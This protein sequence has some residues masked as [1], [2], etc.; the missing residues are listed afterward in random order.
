MTVGIP[1]LIWGVLLYSVGIGPD[2]W[3]VEAIFVILPALGLFGLVYNRY[4]KGPTAKPTQR[5]SV[6]RAIFAGSMGIFYLVLAVVNPRASW[7]A[8]P[9]WVALVAWLLIAADH[10]RNAYRSKGTVAAK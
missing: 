6:T 7:R 5:A 2:W 3:L 8:L 10:L 1:F 4:L 9:N